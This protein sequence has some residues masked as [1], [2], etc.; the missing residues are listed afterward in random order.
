[1]AIEG[2]HEVGRALERG[3]GGGGSGWSCAL[4]EL[5]WPMFGG[6]PGTSRRRGLGAGGRRGRGG[7]GEAPQIQRCIVC[8]CGRRVRQA[9]RLQSRERRKAARAA[10]G[11]GCQLACSLRRSQAQ[12]DCKRHMCVRWPSRQLRRRHRACFA[13]HY[14]CASSQT[15]TTLRRRDGPPSKQSRREPAVMTEQDPSTNCPM[16]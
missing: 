6:Q 8:R 3:G 4:R 9:S 2:A 13:I 10:A 14:R 1:M 12:A 7:A 11:R 15:C 16:A 5:L